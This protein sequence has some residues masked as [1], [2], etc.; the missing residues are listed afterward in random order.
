M[1]LGLRRR[2]ALVTGGSYGI[3][4]AIAV[5]LSAEGCRVAI[6][7]RGADRLAAAAGVIRTAGGECLALQGDVT[8]APDITRAFSAI[9]TQWGGVQVLVN[10]AGGGGGRVPTR[11]HETPE[12][13]WETAMARNADATVRCTMRAIPGMLAGGWG[14]VLTITS[15]QG[16]EG[17]RRPWYCMA[18]TAQTSLMKSLALDP[19]LVRGGIRFNSLAPGRVIFEGSDWDLFRKEDPVRYQERMERELPLGRAGTPEE[20]AAVAVFLCSE[21]GGLVNGAAVA[22]D[23]GE[24][25][26]F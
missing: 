13:V 24:S 4:R 12:T 23:G 7:A 5:A 14:R 9:E 25:R 3:G 10:N 18:K 11:V 21:A 2:V 19:E 15:V 17:G 20:V 8:S 1:D 16:R 6:L 26:S 22:V